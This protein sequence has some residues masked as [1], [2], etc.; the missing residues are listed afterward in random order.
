MKIIDQF[1][2]DLKKRLDAKENPY[3]KA[4]L[5]AEIF[6]KNEFPF[7]APYPS[8]ILDG[9]SKEGKGILDLYVEFSLFDDV[10]SLSD[11]RTVDNDGEKAYQIHLE[12][13]LT[14]EILPERLAEW[15]RLSSSYKEKERS[16]KE[17]LLSVLNEY[18]NLLG[19]EGTKVYWSD[20]I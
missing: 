12:L 8:L 19:T 1:I 20:S 13:S 15:D 9:Y 5:F 10:T 4:L 17:H 3:K 7:P 6:E 11:T 2:E 18:K 14:V 16:E